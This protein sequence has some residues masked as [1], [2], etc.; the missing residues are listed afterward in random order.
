MVLFVFL[1]VTVP[2]GV[3]PGQS[4]EVRAPDGS[5]RSV[6]AIV[7][8]GMTPGSSFMV[9]FPPNT[10]ASPAPSVVASA[11]QP[12]DN[13]DYSKVT[14][15]PPPIEP[16]V[17]AVPVGSAPGATT[18][19][20]TP[21]SASPMPSHF[22]EP[23]LRVQ[24][25]PG[26]PP[27]TTI[28]VQVPGENRTIQAQVPP[29]GVSSFH[30]AYQQQSPP[31]IPPLA[32]PQGEKLLLVRV[33]PGVLP[34]S[35]LHVNIP[36]EPGRVIAAIVPPNVSEFHVSYQPLNPLQSGQPARNTNGYPSHMG[37]RNNY[38][39]NS[40][41]RNSNFSN[42]N[43]RNGYQN[44]DRNQNNGSGMGSMLLPALGGAALGMAGVSM[45]D[46]Y[47]N[48]GYNNDGNAYAD[49]GGG[50]YGGANDY[51]D[52]N[53]YADSRGDY[54][55]GGD[56]YGGGGGDWGGTDDFDGDYGGG[57]MDFGGFGDF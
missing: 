50:D 23:M 14:P 47:H 52:A 36:D 56:D 37:P 2:P 20:A 35:T 10:M 45:Y 31:A 57:D 42:S 44:N 3:S 15:M 28:H 7:P 18:I 39:N 32:P 24:V 54:D 43:G 51:N 55:G 27:G 11:L 53:A 46:H 25:P 41:P 49:N 8:Q 19:S 5:G 12:S 30:V 21:N 38:P 48:N 13:V 34:G 40:G 16:F 6:M 26:T 22:G 17:Q 33:P 4:I 1:S 29:G 9:E